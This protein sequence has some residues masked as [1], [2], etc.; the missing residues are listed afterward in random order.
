M[1][2]LLNEV[3]PTTGTFSKE[4]LFSSAFLGILWNFFGTAISSSSRLLV[5]YSTICQIY[6]QFKLK[7]VV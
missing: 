7:T 3:K 2:S 5:L 6:R 4:G 1:K